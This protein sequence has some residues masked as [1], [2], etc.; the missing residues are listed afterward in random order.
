MTVLLN[1]D[2]PQMLEQF[3]NTLPADYIGFFSIN[4]L[5]EE[6]HAAKESAG[7]G[8]DKQETIRSVRALQLHL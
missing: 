5:R 7:K 1:C 8:E 6:V 3:K 4:N 2:E